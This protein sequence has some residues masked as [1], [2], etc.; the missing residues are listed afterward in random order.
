[1]TWLIQRKTNGAFL[2]RNW[3]EGNRGPICLTPLIPL[4]IT[5]TVVSELF[6]HSCNTTSQTWKA[7]LFFWDYDQPHTSL[8]TGNEVLALVMACWAECSWW[9]FVHLQ[10]EFQPASDDMKSLKSLQECKAVPEILFTLALRPHSS[11]FKMATTILLRDTS[12]A[13]SLF[14]SYLHSM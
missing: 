12:S 8:D 14:P 2:L 4:F 6:L 5:V 1:M 3:A 7:C 10:P 11:S 9:L 13:K